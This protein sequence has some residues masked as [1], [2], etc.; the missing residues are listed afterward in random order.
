ML[1]TCTLTNYVLLSKLLYLL[2]KLSNYVTI[3]INTIITITVLDNSIAI[4]LSV[5]Q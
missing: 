5:S 3:I 1:I 2:S 4:C